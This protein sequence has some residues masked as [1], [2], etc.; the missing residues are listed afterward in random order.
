MS[1]HLVS[2]DSVVGHVLFERHALRIVDDKGR[3]LTFKIFSL[4]LNSFYI[5]VHHG[6]IAQGKGHTLS[7]LDIP[8]RCRHVISLQC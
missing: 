5:M 4:C 6:S 1:L 8:Y 3:P 7:R 2:Y